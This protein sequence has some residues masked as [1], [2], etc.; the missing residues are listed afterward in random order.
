MI[1]DSK[2]CDWCG[3]DIYGEK[4]SGDYVIFKLYN[5]MRLHVDCYEEY[6]DGQS[7]G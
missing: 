1:P 6:K 7:N 4:D 5:G 3:R 2:L